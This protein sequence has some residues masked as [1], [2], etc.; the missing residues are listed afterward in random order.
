MSENKKGLADYYM[1]PQ[2]DQMVADTTNKSKMGESC[3]ISDLEPIFCWMPGFL[4]GFTGT[5]NHGKTTVV[6]FL[7]LIKSVIDGSKWGIWT[8]EM[9]VSI[10]KEGRIQRSAFHVYNLLIHAY[11]GV[12]PLKLMEQDMDKY[13]DA[14]AFIQAHF[15]I[16]DTDR[17]KGHETVRETFRQMHDE[18]GIFGWLIDSFKNLRYDESGGTKDRVLQD[19]VDDF[20]YMTL[21]TNTCGNFILHPRSMKER[22]LRKNGTLK[23]PYKVITQHDLLGGSVWDNSLDSI[24]SWY[25]Q[26]IHD[27]PNSPDGT[28][29]CLKQK[30]QELTNKRGEFD[31]I[32]YDFDRNRFYFSGITPIDG[33]VVDK[34]FMKG[35]P[36]QTQA[37]DMKSRMN[38]KKQPPI[39]NSDTVPF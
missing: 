11:T 9:I 32:I 31:R 26:N 15:F 4:A 6:M 30:M 25:R 35:A 2:F 23:G 20:K 10:K 3:R 37:F 21:E 33:S 28:F 18:L 39:V 8:P 7:M 19:I 36:T 38:G 34:R 24:Y 17:D 27:D 13:M 29:I 22:D 14:L 5:A 1:R 16:I 12:Q